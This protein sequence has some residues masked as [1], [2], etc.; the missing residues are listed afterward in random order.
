MWEIIKRASTTCSLF[1]H[2]FTSIASG[3]V[4][5]C[6]CCVK[7]WVVKFLCRPLINIINT[8]Q[9]FVFLLKLL[10]WRASCC[11][12]LWLVIRTAWWTVDNK[13]DRVVYGSDFWD[14]W[15]WR[16]CSSEVWKKTTILFSSPCLCRS[17]ECNKFNISTIKVV[18]LVLEPE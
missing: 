9:T 3:C 2:L 18:D 4:C 13:H 11:E 1:L 17:A 16:Q 5:S 14:H 6:C 10:P 8:L 12:Q 7:L 15:W